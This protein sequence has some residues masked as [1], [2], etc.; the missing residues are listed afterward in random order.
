MSHA[1]RTHAHRIPKNQ[2]LQCVFQR[3][4]RSSGNAN[5][6][7]DHAY[8]EP[9]ISVVYVAFFR[10]PAERDHNIRTT[11]TNADLHSHTSDTT[12]TR[13]NEVDWELSLTWAST[14]VPRCA[15]VS[16]PA[17]LRNAPGHCLEQGF[18]D[19]VTTRSE[20][21][22][23]GLDP[24]PPHPRKPGA[25]VRFSTSLTYIRKCER[26]SRPRIRETSNFGGVQSD[27]RTSRGTCPAHAE[28]LD[29]CRPTIT[30]A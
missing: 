15:T 9:S 21:E 13:E 12:R 29:S 20:R 5:V 3:P 18:A 25:T 24:R 8:A 19:R 26:S 4:S 2:G 11:P 30:P 27:F 23:H 14:R 7:P 6:I 16:N 10:H 28:H 1:V 17:R 22:S